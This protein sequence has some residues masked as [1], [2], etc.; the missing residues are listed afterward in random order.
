[1]DIKELSV[2]LLKT[3]VSSPS[4]LPLHIHFNTPVNE[5]IGCCWPETCYTRAFIHIRK[6][7][8]QMY[9]TCF[10]FLLFSMVDDVFYSLLFFVC[11][12]IENGKNPFNRVFLCFIT[13]QQQK[14]DV[15]YIL[16]SFFSSSSSLFCF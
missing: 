7:H 2:F 3:N 15:F 8:I 13:K 6:I 4:P 12:V 16:F 9:R 1:M 5:S 14:K 10:A 11:F